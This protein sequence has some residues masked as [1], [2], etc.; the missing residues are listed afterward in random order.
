M[1]RTE[2][3]YAAFEKAMDDWKLYRWIPDFYGICLRIGVET[4]AL[5]AMIYEE[6]G[7]SGQELV[8]FYRRGENI[9]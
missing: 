3:D 1:D 9:P 6:L 2:K 4:A 8:D 5:D 7:Y